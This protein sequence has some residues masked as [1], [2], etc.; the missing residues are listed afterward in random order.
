MAVENRP[1]ML[2]WLKSGLHRAESRSKG[3]KQRVFAVLEGLEK[4][5]R[6]AFAKADASNSSIRQQIY[7]SA[8]SAHE[9]ALL[10]N[11]KLNDAE[12]AARREGLKKTIMRIESEFRNGVNSAPPK[13]VSLAPSVEKPV[14]DRREP[15]VAATRS[16]TLNGGGRKEPEF[17]SLD[18]APGRQRGDAE[19]RVEPVKQAKPGKP[20]REKKKGGL[21]RFAWAVGSLV[22]LGILGAVWIS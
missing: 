22:V 7:E 18:V 21:R 10:T 19:I 2:L 5:I 17:G 20:K 6:N 9:R 1:W 16:E 8:W 11:A 13:A 12:R 15:R 14:P 3:H 4:A